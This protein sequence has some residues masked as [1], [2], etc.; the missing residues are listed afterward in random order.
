MLHHIPKVCVQ[1]L[2]GK[3]NAIMLFQ[4]Y[5]RALSQVLVAA[6]DVIHGIA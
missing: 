2:L 4:Q 3:C 6:D 5:K 1:Y